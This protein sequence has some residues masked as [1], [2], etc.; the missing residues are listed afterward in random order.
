MDLSWG[1]KRKK[2]KTS[3]KTTSP[4]AWEFNGCKDFCDNLI[5]FPK[6]YTGQFLPSSPVLPQGL[7]HALQY[8]KM[9]QY[10]RTQNSLLEWASEKIPTD[11]GIGM[12]AKSVRART[13]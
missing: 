10:L 9:R 5:Q 12:S 8:Y 3:L 4:D 2:K 6:Q 11:F 7:K 1:K 13:T